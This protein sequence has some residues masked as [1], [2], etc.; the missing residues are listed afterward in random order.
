[1]TGILSVFLGILKFERNYKP[2]KS[3]SGA[4]LQRFRIAYLMLKN[5]SGRVRL[6][7]RRFKINQ[8]GSV[9]Q[10]YYNKL[11]VV[12]GFPR[13]DNGYSYTNIILL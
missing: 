7:E 9:L 4:R 5:I 2:D 6:W 10:N 13:L 3:E 8:Y 11:A 12:R 1:M